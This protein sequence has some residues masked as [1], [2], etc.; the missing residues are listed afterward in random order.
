MK[1]SV[2]NIV[3]EKIRDVMFTPTLSW[4]GSSLIGAVIRFENFSEAHLNVIKVTDVYSSSLAQRSSFEKGDFILGTENLV[5]KNID[6]FSNVISV[7]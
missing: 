1:I 5:F 6:D 3:T 4:G 7:L 2:Y